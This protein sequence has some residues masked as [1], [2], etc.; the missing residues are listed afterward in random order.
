[1]LPVTSTNANLTFFWERTSFT[2]GQ[3]PHSGEPYKIILRI[4]KSAS[5]SFYR[6]LLYIQYF[7]FVF[8]IIIAL[9]IIPVIFLVKRLF[10]ISP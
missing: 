6:F 4:L 9:I 5:L 10:L 1:M 8:Q 7:L 2:G 3:V